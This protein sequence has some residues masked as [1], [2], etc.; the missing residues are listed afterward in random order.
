MSIFNHE[1]LKK[2]VIEKLK[3]IFDP[4][5]PVNIYDL[6]L[7]YDISFE[8]KDNYLFCKIL[9][10]L[11]SVGC[12]VAESLISEVKYY[13]SSL[14]EIDE[15][16]VELTFDPPWNKEKISPD[17]LDLLMMTGSFL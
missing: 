8:E 13:T 14:E 4:E 3:H 12:P 17:G 7:I 1:E 6:G 9:M 2:K 15:A 5:I 16:D 10:T 11:T